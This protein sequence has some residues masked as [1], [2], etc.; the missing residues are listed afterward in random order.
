[1]YQMTVTMY[2]NYYTLKQ[3]GAV[4]HYLSINCVRTNGL[5]HVL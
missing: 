3:L 4:H 2:Y 5:I 1:M